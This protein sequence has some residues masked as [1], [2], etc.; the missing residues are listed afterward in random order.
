VEEYRKRGHVHFLQGL[1]N[2]GFAI[3]L[4]VTARFISV[5]FL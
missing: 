2:A 1:E 5:V 4:S 3:S